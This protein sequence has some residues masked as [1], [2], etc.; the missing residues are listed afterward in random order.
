MIV[1]D[2]AEE[3]VYGAAGRTGRR[4]VFFVCMDAD[5]LGGMQRVTHTVAHG[6]GLRGHRVTVIGL[7]RAAAP[8]GYVAE[9]A[10]VHRVLQ[11]S[12]LGRERAWERRLARG[13]LRALFGG[14]T[15][16]VVM[17][18]PGVAAWLD[19]LLP[20]TMRGIG[21]YHGSFEHARA[22]W[23]L[24]GITRHYPELDKAVFLSEEDAGAF[25]AHAL[26]PNAAHLANPL[27]HWPGRVSALAVPR[28]L[29]VGRLEGVK[30]FDR[31]IDAFAAAARTVAERWELHLIGEGAEK[32]RLRA[33][34]AA[35]GVGDRVVFRGRVPAAELERE[36]L[37]SSLLGLTSEHE[38]FPLVLGEAAAHGVPAVAFDV[39]GGV[40]A[41]IRDG[42][43]GVLVPPGD[44]GAFGAVLAG[45]M[46]DPS[47]R[48]RLGAAA[49]TD[50]A[51]LRLDRILDHWEL[52]F[53][54]IER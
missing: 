41:L 37:G 17:T 50:V 9:P 46:A 29:G 8:V 30:R 1:D 22:C 38:G 33:H 28:L 23:H 20:A 49:R 6:L 44:V 21:Q 45:L 32:G 3:T 40:R 53:A 54:E 25:A 43:T 24:G 36:Y 34:A 19:G 31:L 48:R 47:G 26:L 7:H 52:L 42:V 16:Y 27:P 15:G 12:V 11:R 10:Y 18:S 39:S 35:R 13:R 2:V 4:P 5:T 14:V 51:R